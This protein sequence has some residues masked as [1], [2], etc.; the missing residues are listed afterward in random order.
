MKDRT[1]TLDELREHA[2]A[3]DDLIAHPAWGAVVAEAQAQCGERVTLDR[4]SNLCSSQV[5]P[6][7]I[8][9]ATMTLVAAHQTAR[10]LVA[11]PETLA[12]K[13]RAAADR[14]VQASTERDAPSLG[15]DVELTTGRR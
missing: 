11:L 3:L 1:L 7:Q 8:G 9:A 6:E 15:P 13:A 14:I 10:L 2:A 5:P 12:K 4:I